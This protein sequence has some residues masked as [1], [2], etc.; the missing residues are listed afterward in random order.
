MIDLKSSAC[1]SISQ[2]IKAW[3]RRIVFEPSESDLRSFCGHREELSKETKLGFVHYERHPTATI[4]KA[5]SPFGF[6]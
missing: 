2:L 6:S 4:S 1:L 3:A 5:R